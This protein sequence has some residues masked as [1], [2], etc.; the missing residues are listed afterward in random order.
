MD[1]SNIPLNIFQ[2]WITKNLDFG[3]IHCITEIKKNNPEFKYYFFDDINSRKFIEKYYSQEILDTYDKIIPGAYKADLFRYCILYKF[4]G[5]YLDIKYEP[6]NNFKFINF[7]DKEYYV[8][9]RDGFWNDNQIGIYNAFMISYKQNEILLNCINSIVDNVKKIFYGLNGLYPTGPGLLGS[10]FDKDTSFD[11][12]FSPCENYILYKNNKVLK[13][14]DNYRIDQK[15]Y[16]SNNHYSIL[17]LKKEIYINNIE[18][19]KQLEIKNIPLKIYQLNKE[20]IKIKN[21]QNLIKFNYYVYILHDCLYFL[22]KYFGFK[23]F[24]IFMKIKTIELKIDLWKYCY[25][26]YYGGIYIDNNIEL[27][28]DYIN[29][30]LLLENNNYLVNKENQIIYNKI[31]ITEK[32]NNILLECANYIINNYIDLDKNYLDVREAILSSNII[33]NEPKLFLHENI[34]Y[35]YDYE[36]GSIK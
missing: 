23:Y 31:I 11:F 20:N 18:L 26:Y 21:D 32:N 7:I 17:W 30:K 24:N 34:I 5:I 10:F 28:F 33:I 16:Q 35:Y 6:L 29:L 8:K 1:I 2:T 3:M 22:K 36:I 27:N 15:K 14:Y 4:G 9:D 25:L 13:I 19:N 12:T